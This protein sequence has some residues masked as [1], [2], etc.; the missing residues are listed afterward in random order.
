MLK[1]QDVEDPGFM[2]FLLKCSPNADAED[3]DTQEKII[4]RV[5]GDVPFHRESEV[6]LMRML[7]EKGIIPPVYCR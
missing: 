1:F 6:N 5:F 7:S 4:V 2:N 3:D